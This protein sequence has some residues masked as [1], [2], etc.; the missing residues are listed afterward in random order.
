MNFNS[1]LVQKIATISESKRVKSAK[2]NLQSA[3][4]DTQSSV[5]IRHINR[6]MLE[7]RKFNLDIINQREK[8]RKQS[9]I[10]KIK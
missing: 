10:I 2:R 8:I 7:R 4:L 6:Y 5:L 9:K 1:Y 3:I